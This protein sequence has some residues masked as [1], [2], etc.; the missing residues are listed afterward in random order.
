MQSPSRPYDAIAVVEIE[1]IARG[2]VVLDA[3]AKRAPVSV[4][5]VRAVTPGKLLI[6]FGGDVACVGEGIDAARESAGSLLIDELFLPLAHPSLLSALEGVVAPEPGES[7]GVVEITTVATTVWA[8]DLALKACLVAVTRMQLALHIG[9]KGYF[10]LAGPL[11][12]VEAALYAVRAAVP[13]EKLVGAELI[14]QPQGEIR[15]FFS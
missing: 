2:Y 12:D 4:R 14:P 8:A 15:G 9:G 11:A 10:I 7:L 1:S 3:I 13:A 5:W 6:V